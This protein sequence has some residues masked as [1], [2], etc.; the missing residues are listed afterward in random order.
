M[1]CDSTALTRGR[2][3]A[4]ELEGVAVAFAQI[5][6]VRFDGQIEIQGNDGPFSSGGDSGS[7]IVN[8]S[9]RAVGL[10]FAGTDAGL[11]Y[12]NPIDVLLA[13][14]NAELLM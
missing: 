9:R 2:V 14:L 11:T 5:G 7:L 3:T 1:C 6:V 12:A 8:V 4:M 10:M 13:S